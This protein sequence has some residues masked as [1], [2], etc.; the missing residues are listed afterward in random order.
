[1][2]LENQF[3]SIRS[4]YRQI[5]LTLKK[6]ST[7]QHSTPHQN[8]KMNQ[9][10]TTSTETVSTPTP[11]TTPTAPSIALQQ[12]LV[13]RQELHTQHI[14]LQEEL[15]RIKAEYYDNEHLILGTCHHK[16]ERD[17]NYTPQPYEKPDYK[18]YMCGCVEYR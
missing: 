9:Q 15:C 7:T 3:A 16:W 13:R 14:A 2:S 12:L 1:V 6:K 4:I 5:R 8:K 11:L 18:C 10:T 17:R